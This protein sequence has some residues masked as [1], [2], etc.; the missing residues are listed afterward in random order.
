V[1]GRFSLRKS[2]FGKSV[3]ALFLA[4]AVPLTVIGLSDAWFTYQNQRERLDQLL[5]LEAGAAA[6][7]IEGFLDE[8]AS[9][10]GWLV[11]VPWSEERDE[12]RRIDALRLLRQAPAIASIT[13]TDGEGRERVHVSR[14]NLTRTEA[15]TALQSEPSFQGA[16]TT[17]IW[18][19]PV[20]YVAGPSLTSP[21][22]WLANGDRQAWSLPR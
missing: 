19:S 13:L 12:R 17:R 15:R 18:F 4:A 5:A 10:L 11:H 6:H 3:L 7:R 9:Q 16:L 21:S 22:L 8:I 20:S 1:A 2:L 14:T